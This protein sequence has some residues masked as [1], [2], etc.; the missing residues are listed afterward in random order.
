MAN[1]ST[2]LKILF[3]LINLSVN[4]HMWAGTRIIYAD[5]SVSRI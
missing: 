4:S 2:D 1:A 3:Y 5:Y